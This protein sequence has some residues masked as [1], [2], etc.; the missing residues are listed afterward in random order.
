MG[1]FADLLIAAELHPAMIFY[2]NLQ[3]SVGP[4]S[5]LGKNGARG[6]MKISAARFSSFIP[7]A[8]MAAIL[9]ATSPL[10]PRS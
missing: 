8:S 6:S 3:G 4:N 10:W 7:W 9:N 5:H 1:Y 2:L